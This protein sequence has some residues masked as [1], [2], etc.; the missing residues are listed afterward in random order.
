[1]HEE[2]ERLAFV[3]VVEIFLE[4]FRKQVVYMHQGFPS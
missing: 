3:G 4:A 2:P 1:M